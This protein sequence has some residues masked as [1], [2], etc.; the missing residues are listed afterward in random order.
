M[1]TFDLEQTQRLAELAEIPQ[2]QR[3]D[4]W[5]A[6]FLRAAPNASLASFDPQIQ[7]GPDRFPYF[8]LALPD[9]GPFTPFSMVHILNDVLRDGTDADLE[10]LGQLGDRGFSERK[11]RQDR[12]PG[13]IGEG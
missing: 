9:P 10:R 5:C 3:D 4:A 12:A 8:Q 7:A 2:P 13:G 11:L 1:E 6:S